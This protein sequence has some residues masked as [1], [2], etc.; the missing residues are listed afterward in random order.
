MSD[1][2][3]KLKAKGEEVLTQLSAELLQNPRFVKAMQG[4]MEGAAKGKETLDR[5]VTRTLKSMNLPTR[6][7]VR[8]LTSRID[9]LES[10]LAAFKAKAKAAAKAKA[11]ATPAARK[12]TAPK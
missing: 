5:G 12:K 6:G 11:K 1:V 7:D 10:E 2:F 4:A 9:A 3:D 8:K